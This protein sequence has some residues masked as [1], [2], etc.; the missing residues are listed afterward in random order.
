VLVRGY[1]CWVL[2]G[3]DFFVMLRINV[4]SLEAITLDPKQKM[5]IQD[6]YMKQIQVVS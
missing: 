4:C 3:C 6:K 5:K 2:G 1:F